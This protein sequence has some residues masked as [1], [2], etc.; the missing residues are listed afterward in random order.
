M[1]SL[2]PQEIAFNEWWA[3]NADDLK[4]QGTSK[5]VCRIGWNAAWQAAERDTLE[6]AAQ[7]GLKECKKA[8]L[9][10]MGGMV[11]NAIRALQGNGT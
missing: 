2:T 11:Y 10:N 6:R 9:S 4:Y 3:T 1:T 5:T 7:V 8:G